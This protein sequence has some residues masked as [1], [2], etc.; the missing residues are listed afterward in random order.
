M[1]IKRNSLAQLALAVLIA[2]VFTSCGHRPKRVELKGRAQGTYYS[3]IYYTPDA[4][5]YKAE[6]DSI[7]SDFDMSMSVYNPKSLVSR[8]NSGDTTAVADK[9]LLDNL[10]LSDYMYHETGGAFDV[11][12]AP[13]F[14]FWGFGS[15]N[16][17][18]MTKVAN[19]QEQDEEVRK[20][21]DVIG[22]DKV[23]YDT[24]TGRV[25]FAQPGM[26]LNFNAIAQ[27]YSVGVVC[28]FLDSKCI[29]N[30]LVEIGGEVY[31]KGKNA[32]GR[33]WRVGIEQ[34]ADSSESTRNFNE[35]I[36]I[37]D[38]SVVT[39]GNY[40]K[41][42]ILDGKRYSHTI[43][44]RTGYPAD[45]GVLSATVIHDDPAYADAW[46]TTFMVVGLD[47]AKKILS[48]HPEMT[49]Y[50]IYSTDDGYGVWRNDK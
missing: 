12:G 16:S 3:I 18:F 19:P 8:I 25:G 38:K 29:D 2:S 24:V 39:S 9:Y 17:D 22:F 35:V 43:D 42:Y 37:T 46:A 11:S 44:P 32:S 27:G 14:D 50:I 7:L 4:T 23:S 10:R 40:R 1:C 6:I 47:E 5:N 13:L 45:N 33:M 28:R 41:Y 34:P 15:G 36:E 49:A 31:A 21:L 48:R 20:L 30:Y 26:R